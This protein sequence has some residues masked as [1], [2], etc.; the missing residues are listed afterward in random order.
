MPHAPTFLRRAKPRGEG[1]AA[2]RLP[3]RQ[4]GGVLLRQLG[5]VQAGQRQVHPA[6]HQPLPVHP[7]GL[8]F[9]RPRK[10]RHLETFRRVSGH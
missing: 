6:E 2:G 10:G 9:R 8:R 4:K 5:C 1:E 3:R 7:P